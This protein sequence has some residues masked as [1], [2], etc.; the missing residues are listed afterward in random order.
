MEK[1]KVKVVAMVAE[2]AEDMLREE[3]PELFDDETIKVVIV[4]DKILNTI[5]ENSADMRSE[6]NS[7]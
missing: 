6:E 5:F 3:I 4:R 2:S 1:R 7:K